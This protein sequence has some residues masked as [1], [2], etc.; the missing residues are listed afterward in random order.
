[1]TVLDMLLKVRTFN[2]TNSTYFRSAAFYSHKFD[3]SAN[4]KI[5]NVKVSTRVVTD[6]TPCQI[7]GQ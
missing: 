3:I 1:M 5:K 2:P 7:K 6:L 4:F